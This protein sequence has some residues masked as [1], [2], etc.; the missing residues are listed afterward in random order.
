M[1][2]S[3]R[4]IDTRPIKD[5]IAEIV[6]KQNLSADWFKESLAEMADWVDTRWR[7]EYG[8]LAQQY[9]EAISIRDMQIAELK[10]KLREIAESRR[11]FLDV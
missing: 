11:E 7:Y 5:K 10:E 3:T 9:A 8:K 6:E 1:E 2:V 4:I